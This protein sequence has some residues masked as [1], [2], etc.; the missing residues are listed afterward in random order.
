MGPPTSQWSRIPNRI[1]QKAISVFTEIINILLN[2]SLTAVYRFNFSLCFLNV[3]PILGCPDLFKSFG[4]ISRKT[5]SLFLNIKNFNILFS[6]IFTMSI[7]CLAPYILIL[8]IFK[9]L[10]FFLRPAKLAGD[11]GNT[12]PTIGL[13][14][15]LIPK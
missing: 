13:I 7:I 8:F 12:F 2:A 14:K 9:I 6:L 4:M 15:G 1:S 3:I 11:S 10:S 5:S